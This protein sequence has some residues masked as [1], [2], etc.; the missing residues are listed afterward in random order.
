MPVRNVCE[1]DNPPGG[2]VACEPHQMAICIVKDGVA[3]GECLDPPDTGD[4]GETSLANWALAQVSGD[5]RSAETRIPLSA[6]AVLF[7]GKFDRATGEVVTFSIPESVSEAIETLA[8]KLLRAA[9]GEEQ[10][11]ICG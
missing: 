6:L 5:Y 2:T 9:E 8:A 3:R 10:N 1:C 7:E 4:D 11:A